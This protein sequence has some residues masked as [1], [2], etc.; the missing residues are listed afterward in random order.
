MPIGIPT[1]GAKR[2]IESHSVT[3]EAKTSKCSISF[4]AVKTF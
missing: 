1:K 2:E 3:A 4:K